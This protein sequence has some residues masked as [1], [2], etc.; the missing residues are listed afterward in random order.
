MSAISDFATKQKAHN[1]QMD[2]AIDGLTADVTDLKKQIAALQSSAGQITPEDQA[3]LDAIDV[4]AETIASKLS[5]L[6]AATPPTL[7]PVPESGGGPGDGG[8]GP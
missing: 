3:L 8:E 5:A 4:R 6:D 2:A 1:D 7:P